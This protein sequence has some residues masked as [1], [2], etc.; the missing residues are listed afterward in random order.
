MESVVSISPTPTEMS[1]VAAEL[2]ARLA[3]EAV[4]ARGRFLVSLSGGGTPMALYRLLA[5]S[6]YRE[7]LP[8]AQMYFFWGDER[9]VPPEDAESCYNQ[10]QMALL[11]QVPV[12]QANLLR[13]KGELGPQPAARAYA[14]VLKEWADAGL[15]WPRFD[16]VLLGLGS[17]GHTAS[18]FPGSVETSGLATVAVTAHYQDRPANRVSLTPD[19]FNAARVVAF[20]AVGAE[21]ADALQQTLG[22]PRE[23]LRLPAQRIQPVEGQLWWLVDE[24]AA[25]LLPD[26][27]KRI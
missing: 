7:S 9:C 20:L 11:R 4:A 24:A 16:L 18:L 14:A 8:W 6:P 19:V 13:V 17:D 23:P 5:G 2:F 27:L 12:P 15:D 3:H 22:G 1:R 10:A 26:D 25:R 21:K